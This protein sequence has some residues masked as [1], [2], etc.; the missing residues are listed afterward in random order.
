M[1]NT[2]EHGTEK[3]ESFD[4]RNIVIPELPSEAEVLDRLEKTCTSVGYV[5]A[6]SFLCWQYNFIGFDKEIT[7]D[8]VQGM[9]GENRLLR[10][11]I[12]LLK[13]LM[14][15]AEID[16][17]FPG[18]I[19]IQEYIDESHR[20]LQELHQVLSSA[21]LHSLKNSNPELYGNDI[22]T[23]PS[24]LRE[25]IFYSSESAYDFQYKEFSV[26][27]H[28]AD[29]KWMIEKMG[30]SPFELTQFYD[31]VCALTVF[32]L[33]E[34]KRSTNLES[35]DTLTLLPAFMFLKY[36]IISQTGL[37]EDTVENII[38]AFSPSRPAP[39]ETY[40]HVGSWNELTS[41]PIIRISNDEFFLLQSY[42]FIESA[43][44]SPFYWM[45]NDKAYR[46]VAAENRG[47]FTESFAEL[48]LE[49]IF[50][51][52]RIFKN[53]Y[54][55]NKSGDSIGEIDVLVLYADRAIVLQAKSKRLGEAARKGIE[56]ALKSDFEKTVQAAYDQGFSCGECL[57]DKNLVFSKESGEKITIPAQI[58]EIFIIC[59]IAEHFPGL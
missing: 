32:R 21:Y 37:K 22:F 2:P 31:G 56:G 38:T 52:N 23:D 59:L 42:S 11:E 40:R 58:K 1:N 28:A 48:R 53:I 55:H 3:F 20:L 57:M 50:E 41:K 18:S 47:C 44:E 8:A 27:R 16:M 45:I 7:P 39:L 19:K 4:L 24:V 26:L 10:S 33:Q 14:Y 30:F 29:A 12:A 51:K 15:S 43:Y 34:I 46:N 5:H 35:I 49:N 54:I 25:P 13:R 36:D 9:K 6:L 17:T